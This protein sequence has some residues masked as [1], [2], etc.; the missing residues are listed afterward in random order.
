MVE[1][2]DEEYIEDFKELFE[3]PSTLRRLRSRGR[4]IRGYF[5]IHDEFFDF[6]IEHDL[7]AGKPD[8]K[9]HITKLSL[10]RYDFP[11]WSRE[12][13]ELRET[14]L[15]LENCFKDTVR[16][17]IVF[18]KLKNSVLQL[19]ENVGLES[20]V[21]LRV[22]NMCFDALRNVRAE[23]LKKEQVKALKFVIENMDENMDDFLAT[24]LEDILI[25]SGLEPIPI[26]EG[27]ADLY[28]NL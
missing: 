5:V 9:L 14:V 18:T 12:K 10:P 8:Q 26:I 7:H 11:R 3:H 28:K 27:I 15:E 16:R 24:E 17:Q 2:T 23:K 4:V 13:E 20:R 6:E 21:F 25:E 1:L 19:R 22:L